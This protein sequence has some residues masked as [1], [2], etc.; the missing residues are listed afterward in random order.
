MTGF[1][2]K[3]TITN[4]WLSMNSICY[5]RNQK[6][7]SRVSP[8]VC[9]SVDQICLCYYTGLLKQS[10]KLTGWCKYRWRHHILNHNSFISYKYSATCTCIFST[11]TITSVGWY[12]GMTLVCGG[13]FSLIQKLNWFVGHHLY[14]ASLF[15][16]YFSYQYIS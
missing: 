13:Q 10:K 7:K 1:L 14:V 12:F 11:V 16:L 4:D 15:L 2:V 6:S 3:T 8:K 9:I 5:L